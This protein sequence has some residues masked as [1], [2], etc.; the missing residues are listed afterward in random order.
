[1]NKAN[2]DNFK[3]HEFFILVC[4]SEEDFSDVE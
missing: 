1:M 2:A 3:G 4:Q